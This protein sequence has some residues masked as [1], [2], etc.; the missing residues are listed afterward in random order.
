[1]RSTSFFAHVLGAAA[2]VGVL[3]MAF[4]LS[5]RGAVPNLA[6]VP[7]GA[8]AGAMYAAT[9]GDV[10]T[11]GAGLRALAV[12]AVLG[13]L[14]GVLAVGLRLPSWA[15]SVAVGLLATGLAVSV[16][17]E[18]GLV[19]AV[20]PF[21]TGRVREFA[22]F[23]VVSIGAGLLCL[24]PR[25]RRTLGA[26]RDDPG[27]RA[28]VVAVLVLVASSVVA[29]VGGLLLVFGSGSSSPGIALELWLPLAAVV[30]GGASL[31]GRRVGVTGTVLGVLLLIAVREVW[32]ASDAEP[33]V[34]GAGVVLALAG[35]GGIVGLL[36][37]PL[38]EWSGRRAG[39]R[40]SP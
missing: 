15:A 24:V 6:V 23:A 21:A 28:G 29:G 35:I 33:A 19:S 18:E 40:R 31:Y 34:T 30:L 16:A 17:P 7:L 4:S 11:T 12:A 2:P 20:P 36:A 22:V 32:L 14:I 8:L 5:L 3:A 39:A 37:T 27:V 26:Y 9:L 10:G 13:L 25:V 38:V 1:V